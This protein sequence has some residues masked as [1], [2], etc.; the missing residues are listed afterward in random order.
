NRQ[1]NEISKSIGQAPDA[2]QREARKEEGR[3]KREEKER[4]QAEIDR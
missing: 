4:V 3:Q 2:D 1:A